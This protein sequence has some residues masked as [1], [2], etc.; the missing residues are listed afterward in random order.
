MGERDSEY[1][2]DGAAAGRLLVGVY[3]H[4]QQ[5]CAVRAP[6]AGGRGRMFS[7]PFEGQIDE[8]TTCIHACLRFRG[9][10][11]S[12]PPRHTLS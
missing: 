5:A 3:V 6:G 11:R 7:D 2:G 1:I 4:S 10:P 12:F 8:V 9:A